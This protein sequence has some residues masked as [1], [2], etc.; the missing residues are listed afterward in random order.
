MALE[1][2]GGET[3]V[4]ERAQAS[5]PD[6]SSGSP[7]DSALTPKT[8]AVKFEDGGATPRSCLRNVGATPVPPKAARTAAPTREEQRGT[9]LRLTL[10]GNMVA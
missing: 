8:P 4:L 9:D 3:S 10:Y 1:R 2:V 6:G 5:N 7:P